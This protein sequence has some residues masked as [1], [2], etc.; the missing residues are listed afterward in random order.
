MTELGRTERIKNA[1]DPQFATVLTTPYFF[2]RR[3]P[4]RF[5]V[6]DMDG[7]SQELRDHDLIGECETTI[8]A[9]VGEHGGTL[10]EQLTYKGKKRERGSLTVVAEEVKAAAGEAIFQIQGTKLD[11]KDF[12]GKSD[13]FFK[14]FRQSGGGWTCVGTSEVIMKNLDPVWQPFRLAIGK[15]CNGDDQRPLKFEVYDWDSDGGHD[16]IGICET[17]LA[18]LK[19]GTQ[20]LELIRAKK[21]G[22][23]NYTNSGVLTIRTSIEASFTFLDFLRNGYGINVS[24]AVDFTGSN[25]S[26]KMPSSLHYMNPMA[27]NEYMQA[28]MGIGTILADYDSDKLFPAFGYGAKFPNGT[29]SHDFA[30]NGN[31]DNPF[32]SGVPGV[33]TAYQ[34]ALHTVDLWGPTNFA[35]IIS[36]MA[37][38]AEAHSERQYH[39]LLII[40]DGQITD[41]A[42]TKMAIIKASRLPMSIV[43]IGVGGADFSSMEELDSDHQALSHNGMRAQRDIVQFV[44][45]R[46]Y[47]SQGPPALAQAVLAEIPSQFLCHMKDNNIRP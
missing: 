7:S 18:Q 21:V 37:G 25:G 45:F 46:Q 8:G 47:A 30:L 14:I 4:V 15:L 5:A 24:F 1:S 36:R 42:D 31:G 27:P 39:V 28:I 22:R 23:K 3:Q 12:F 29:V 34:Q 16:L 32:C 6:Y 35:P 33:I 13:P 2:E 44:P 38:I 10:H 26:P 9:L 19:S 20:K 41:M 40:T 11:K 17:T 43:I